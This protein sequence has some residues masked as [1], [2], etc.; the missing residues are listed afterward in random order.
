MLSE[1]GT[2]AIVQDDLLMVGSGQRCAV[3][4]VYAILFADWPAKNK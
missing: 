2:G 1:E 3:C 4:A